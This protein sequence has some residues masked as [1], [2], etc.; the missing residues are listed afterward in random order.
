MKLSTAVAFAFVGLGIAAGLTMGLFEVEGLA[1]SVI[2]SLIGG[3]C[4]VTVFVLTY[5]EQVAARTKR[6][7]S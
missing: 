6:D 7:P 4:F 5:R 2:Y 1:K 3:A